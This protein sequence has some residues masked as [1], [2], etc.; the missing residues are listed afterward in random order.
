MPTSKKAITTSLQTTR[1]KWKSEG[2]QVML[3]RRG[4]LQWHEERE[5]RMDLELRMSATGLVMV[6][7]NGPAAL[8]S[9]WTERQDWEMVFPSPLAN[10]DLSGIWWQ[11]EELLW[12]CEKHLQCPN[13]QKVAEFCWGALLGTASR[14]VLLGAKPSSG[15]PGKARHLKGLGGLLA[16]TAKGG[17]WYGEIKCLLFCLG[18]HNSE[19]WRNHSKVHINR[20]F[21]LWKYRNR[22]LKFPTGYN[23][24]SCP[25]LRLTCFQR[26]E[27]WQLL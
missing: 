9:S 13:F 8:M 2:V 3:E 16:L 18:E 5:E 27:K 21:V 22:R 24:N 4:M 23:Y 6:L 19:I 20:N 17:E 11:L 26:V 12:W 25:L 14:H 10:Q 15:N 7:G 1:R